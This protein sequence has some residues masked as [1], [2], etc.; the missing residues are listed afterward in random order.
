[1]LN[2]KKEG[3]WGSVRWYVYVSNDD[4]FQVSSQKEEEEEE[5]RTR[6]CCWRV[7]TIPSTYR[8]VGGFKGGMGN[9]GCGMVWYGM[10]WC[11]SYQGGWL[12]DEWG[13]GRGSL[14]VSM[15]VIVS[16]FR[17]FFGLFFLMLRKFE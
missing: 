5:G 16:C 3:G 14:L 12:M 17:I 15:Y 4:L 7:G 10:V 9:V 1:M 6:L 2:R 11:R 13:T 8:A